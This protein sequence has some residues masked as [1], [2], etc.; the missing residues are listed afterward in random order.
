MIERIPIEL[1]ELIKD[2]PVVAYLL[3]K[4]T[5]KY[6]ILNTEQKES[7]DDDEVD[8]VLWEFLNKYEAG[9]EMKYTPEE[10]N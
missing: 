2:K 4:I 3:L 1:V 7:V 10:L 8:T 5:T 6:L 9:D